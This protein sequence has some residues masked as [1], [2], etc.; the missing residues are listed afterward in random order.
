MNRTSYLRLLS[1]ALGRR[2][3]YYFGTRGADAR[4][5][6]DLDNFEG[7]FSQIAP[8]GMA[9]VEELC[10]EEL[11]GHRVDLDTYSVD[12]DDS[13]H[14]G[15]LRGAML[16]SFD[17][18]AAVIPYRSCAV[19]ASAWFPRSE[20]TLHLGNFHEF[21]GTF[22][23]KPWVESRLSQCGVRTVP[24]RYFADNERGLI[25]EMLAERPLVVRANLS[26]GGTGVLFIE[27]PEALTHGW[28]EHADGFLGVTPFLEGTP[29]NINGVVFEGGKVSRHGVSVQLVG[30]SGC[31]THRFRY[32]GNDYGAAAGL[33]AQDLE[34]LD[35]MLADVGRW[36]GSHGYLGAF[37]IDVIMA[38]SGPHLVE[39]NPRFQGSSRL[40]ASLDV[41]DERADMFIAHIGAFLGAPPP[42]KSRLADHVGRPPAAH[43]VVHAEQRR[44]MRAI[45]SEH[46]RVVIDLRPQ[47]GVEVAR[48]AMIAD[49]VFNEIV[50]TDGFSL[51]PLANV[52]VEV[53]GGLE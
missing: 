26:D 28:P 5:L 42:D 13:P 24:W 18:L 15:A 21:Q 30:L 12:K 44:T 14:V 4:S 10:L 25:E 40:S 53:C 48:S 36:L 43:V 31:T 49:L 23:H 33:D 3:V 7:I 35:T 19:L 6:T 45:P 39:L 37:G 17:Q 9:G 52:V 11:K 51:T 2:R 32:C 22:D 1:R 46:G 47:P 34:A 29:I 27:S 20:K 16:E 8:S 50:T 38:E 41:E